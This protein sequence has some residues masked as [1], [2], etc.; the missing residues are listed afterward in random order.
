MKKKTKTI[1]KGLSIFLVLLIVTQ[2]LPLQV[3]AENITDAIAHKEF[4]ED[5]V[6]NPTSVEDDSNAE[7]LYE[8]EEKRD[9][10]T[11]VYKKSDGSYTAVMTEEPLH[12]LY[13]GEWEE[14]NNSMSLNGNLYT[15]L[16][17]LFNV[18]LPE[19][20]DSNENLTV[21]KDGYELSF[22]VDE[23]E[24]SSATVEN[25]VVVS[26]TNIA[27]ADEAIS[28]TQSSVTYN[29]VA[30]NTDLQYI[31]T[32]NSIKENIIVS[33]KES[34]K[35]TYTF[36]FETNGL[37]AEKLDDG[38]VVFKDE[39]DEIKFRIPRPIMTDSSLAFS[40][41]IGVTLIED[42]NGTVALEYSPSSEW[43][44][45]SDRTYPITIDPAIMVENSD[46]SWVEDTWVAFDS[47]NSNIQNA[48]G[49]NDCI[50]VLA[51]QTAT[52][53][54]G[55]IVGVHSEIYTKF[56]INALKSLGDDIVFTEVQYLFVGATADGKALAKEIKEYPTTENEVINLSNVTYNTKPT[57]YDEVIDYYTSPYSLKN[58]GSTD[59]S[60]IHFN[61]TKQLNKWYAGDVN[62]GFAVVAGN[63]EYTGLFVLN[64]VSASSSDTNT[65]TTSIVLDYVDMGGYN[66]NLNYHTQSAGRAGTGYVND[67]TQQLSV[68]R[69][70]VVIDE[71]IPLAIGMTYNSVA[72]EK[73]KSLNYN[74]ML[75]YGN[76]WLPNF[77]RAYLAYDEDKFTYYTDT[78]STIDFIR[79]TDNLGNITFTESYSNEHENHDYSV[80]YYPPS[81]GNDSYYTVIRPDGLVERFNNNGLLVSL[82]NPNSTEEAILVSYDSKLR[83]DNMVIGSAYKAEYKYDNDNLLSEIEIKSVTSPLAE[84]YKIT[85]TYD[86]SNNLI[87]VKSYNGELFE[88]SYDNNNNMTS[89]TYVKKYRVEY[90]YDTNGKIKKVTEQEYNETD[91]VVG[92]KIT[93]DRLSST[94]IK[95]T[96]GNKCEIYQFSNKGS[97]M[98]KLD[99][100]QTIH[101]T[102]SSESNLVK[103]GGF[104]NG[105]QEWT[106]TNVSQTT[107]STINEETVFAV[108][109][110]GGTDEENVIYQTISIDGKKNDTIA[111]AGWLKGCFVNSSTNNSTLN[112]IIMESNDLK[113]LNFTN[114]RYAQIEVAYQYK[115]TEDN[116]EKFIDERVVIPFPENISDWQ[117]TS[118]G[119]TLKGDCET[120]TLFIRY[121]K[122]A[123]KAY[124]SNIELIKN[125]GYEL[126]YNDGQLSGMSL[127]LRDVISYTYNTEGYVTSVTYNDSDNKKTV[128]KIEY[129]NNSKPTQIKKNGKTKYTFSYTNG[130]NS[131]ILSA[132]NRIIRY[133]DDFGNLSSFTNS[134]FYS[135]K[136]G[137]GNPVEM[138]DGK[139]YKTKLY[140][141]D[142]DVYGTSV[143]KSEVFVENNKAISI[144]STQDWY[145]RRSS[146][147]ISTKNDLVKVE[148]TFGYDEENTEFDTL[149][150]VK[151]YSNKIHSE[152]EEEIFPNSESF[153]YEYDENGNIIKEYDYISE[154]S[155][156]LRYSYSY[157][158][159]NRLIRYDD[160]VSNPRRSYSFEYD[161]NGNLASKSTYEYTQPGN[162]LDELLSTEFYN[163]IPT[164]LDDATLTWN[165]QQ[166]ESYEISDDNNIT[167]RVEYCYDENGL[168]T[169]KK[170]YVDNVLN[171]TYCYTWTYGKLANQVYIKE[172]TQQTKHTIKYIYDSF[173]SVQGFILD[174][175]E[176]FLFLKNLFG[177]I[178]GL[179]DNAGNIVVS[180]EY[181][182]WGVPT[183]TCDNIEIS[184]ED[185]L[186]M[187]PLSYRSCCYDYY[188]GLY[189]VEGRYYNPKVG[190]FINSS[191]TGNSGWSE[192][193]SNYS[194]FS[195]WE[196][197]P[198]W[199]VDSDIR[200]TLN[201]NSIA[202]YL[203]NK[204]VTNNLTGYFE[205]NNGFIFNQRANE[206]HQYR[207]GFN[208]VGNV[209]C[210][211]VATYNTLLLLDNQTDSHNIIPMYFHDVIREYEQIG[212]FAYNMGVHP[213]ATAQ[214]FI[215]KNYDVNIIFSDFDDIVDDENI[216]N[217]V[218]IMHYTHRYGTHYVAIEYE[219]PKF[220][221]YNAFCNK[222]TFDEFDSIATLY[223]KEKDNTYQGKI[224]ISISK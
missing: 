30:E 17:N 185:I 8:V 70:D 84:P 213:F 54:S 139:E 120:I 72:F 188:S 80:E 189:Y 162:A 184:S 66:E 20:I 59:F 155:M 145:G 36:T 115:I 12:Y 138:F 68:I 180:Y 114:D 90:E 9:E 15:N 108:E 28:Q 95:I 51:N 94:Q 125:D 79:S 159:D 177:D 3:L 207:F 102:L 89:M 81:N 11:K 156:E 157:D 129:Q 219:N 137:N 210:G 204:Q 53:D 153:F 133:A 224:L 168:M 192:I 61:I 110:P 2:I 10:Y 34:V 147:I 40:Y 45:D 52:D 37:N 142:Y 118:G 87:G 47:S 101:S 69:D 41:D 99:G 141:V 104:Q 60:Y 14:I 165:G 164:L 161:N 195:Y 187:L 148:S 23:I 19:T 221:G 107:Q 166:L 178:I 174:H 144:N 103:N 93:Y 201:T 216:E 57:L 31:V 48:N 77:L 44:N 38:S 117:Y 154:N 109:F 64:G 7:I 198:L 96:N 26:D 42:E 182:P 191:G 49:Y 121:S 22:S 170:V 179:V 196:N 97:L 73:I 135:I 13:N 202:N 146:N 35:D 25:N 136:N 150:Q 18:E 67:F 122:N 111:V 39:N 130:V 218:N 29:D 98:Y 190:N 134:Y 85:Y 143:E 16:D 212:L 65:Y 106:T 206:M 181:T 4:I 163:T 172:G 175:T 105:L 1:R 75:A 183:I 43:I 203:H 116:Q 63:E 124:F 160:S 92:N 223:D 222:A 171:E 127:G 209:G 62:N 32:P 131:S 71:K 46:V 152:N 215:K 167:T 126:K 193:P 149:N 33:N 82:S 128:I 199:Y 217:I 123:N 83:I 140:D 91:Y 220:K 173:N 50:A 205:S 27:V 214:F 151:I 197:H 56:N 55:N 200:E 21:E 211:L 86:N 74:N 208:H 5:V 119:F 194:L 186:K 176:T 113:V 132:D 88:Y 24:E 100:A 78:G 169:E 76:N 58:G 6:N 158:S 112:N